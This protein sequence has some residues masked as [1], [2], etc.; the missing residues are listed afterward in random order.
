[1]VE[2]SRYFIPRR[3]TL[4]NDRDGSSE[5]RLLADWAHL[6]A[7]VLLA[8]PGAGKSWAFEQEALLDAFGSKL[9]KARDFVTLSPRPDWHGKTLFIDGLDEMRV[10]AGQQDGFDGVRRRLDGLGQPRFRLSCREAD[11]LGAIDAQ[12]LCAVAPGGEVAVLR[13]EPLQRADIE[14]LLR[15]GPD[16]VPGVDEFM[17]R[18]DQQQALPLLSNPLMLR[19]MVNALRVRDDQWPEG[20][21][22]TYQLACEHLATEVNDFHRKASRNKPVNVDVLLDDAGL[23]CAV[24]LLANGDAFTDNPLSPAGNNMRVDRLPMA[25]GVRDAAAVFASQIFV[26]EG[27]E[28]YPRHRTIAEYLAARSIAKRV[29]DKNLS[30]N[31][32]LSLMSLDGGIVEPL[33]GLNAWLAV[34]CRDHPRRSLGDLD[35]LGVVLYGDVRSFNALEKSQVLDS[36]HREALRFRWFRGSHWDSHPFGALGTQDMA[37]AFL[38]LLSSS[39]RDPAHQ[40]LLDC[41]LDAVKHGEDMPDLVNALISMVRDSSYRAD[42]RSAALDAWWRQSKGDGPKAVGLLDEIRAGAIDDP[43]AELCGQLLAWLYPTHL[44]AVDALRHLRQISGHGYIYRTFWTNEFID[45]IPA[46]E[47]PMVVDALAAQVSTWESVRSEYEH[48]G[49]IGE[50]IWRGLNYSGASET[51]QRLYQWLSAGLDEYESSYLAQHES[52]KIGDWLSEHPDVQKRLYLHAVSTMPA[53]PSQVRLHIH[54][55]T[56]RFYGAARPSDWPKWLLIQAATTDNAVFAQD[57]LVQAALESI[58]PASP[59]DISMEDVEGWLEKHRHQWSMPA[60]DRLYDPWLSN[61]WWL[62]LDHWQGT[63]LQ[64]KRERDAAKIMAQQKRHAELC[65]HQDAIKSGT[66]PAGLMHQITLAYEKRF[67]DIEGVTP[68]ARVQNFLGGSREDALA[69]IEGIKLVLSRDDLPSV[70][71][72]LNLDLKQQHHWIRPVCLL[73]A[74]LI[75][76]EQ[77]R[78]AVR[79]SDALSLKMIAF[80]LTDRSREVHAWHRLLVEERP[81][82]VAQVMGPYVQGRILKCAD[83]PIGGLWA[84]AQEGGHREVARQ[85]LPTL[86]R[87]FPARAT[88]DQLRELTSGLLLAAEKH[89]EPEVFKGIVTDRLTLKSLDAG[90]RITWMVVASHID[91]T[92]DSGALLA[93]IGRSQARAAHLVHALQYQSRRNPHWASLPVEVTARLVEL[94]AP[95]AAP[96]FRE[97]GGVVTD[98]ERRR[99]VVQ[100]LIRQLAALPDALAGQ[101]LQRLR[102][103]P[104]LKHWFVELD[105]SLYEHA[106]VARAAHFSHA[107]DQDVALT[108]ANQA[109]ANALDLVALLVDQLRIIEGKIRGDETNGL[110]LFRRDDKETPKIENDCRDILMDKLREPLLKHQVDLISEARAAQD[111]RVDLRAVALVRGQRVAVPIEVK[112][113]QDKRRESVWLAWRD[114]LDRLYVIDPA[115]QGIGLYVAIWFGVKPKANPEGV[116]PK[117]AQDMERLL[118]ERIPA[119]ERHRLK[120]VVLDLSWP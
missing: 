43:A 15:H 12:A 48:H 14:D 22:D 64:R 61:I 73:A 71:E 118:I 24:L 28:R 2:A 47:L 114:Q 77:P 67:S 70:E 94:L 38:A 62:P 10:S 5:T 4:Q 40:S 55:A 6:D 52:T 89:L 49:F 109:P 58:N 36:L 41:V 100:P 69:A 79:W 91:S 51:T 13:L 33:R 102:S 72:I 57:C 23:L 54:N 26:T 105:A 17:R 82:L 113:D 98:S 50:L 106:R 74:E 117:S 75:T 60:D 88:R 35:P 90:Q 104:A 3:A 63:Q 31:R 53:D 76:L 112:F 116:M 66:A 108:L 27:D 25:L 32:V 86:L 46:D 65:A 68:E 119:D 96:E 20:R 11:W 107:S 111:K 120:V 9:L 103:N 16:P 7:Y 78:A 21:R 110:K 45:K 83:S 42:V 8:E 99:D 93:F 101:A 97:G 30:I 92:V 80:Y 56:A 34:H 59:Y 44:S 85:I 115:S 95:H 19:L 84:L 87:R 81:E 37:P 18:A 1:M 29:M 39:S